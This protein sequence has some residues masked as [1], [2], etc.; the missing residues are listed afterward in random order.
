MQFATS[1]PSSSN[2]VSPGKFKK[3]VSQESPQSV[4]EFT[5]QIEVRD[6]TECKETFKAI[7]SANT[8]A[9]KNDILDQALEYFM[10]KAVEEEK[11]YHSKL[12]SLSNTKEE[13]AAFAQEKEVRANEKRRW[14]R[15]TDTN[16]VEFVSLNPAF[17]N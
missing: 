7:Q 17:K 3:T 13:I 12:K 9:A 14:A 8:A 2:P 4:R 11:Q 16:Q 10:Q 1:A 6:Q 15:K 5:K